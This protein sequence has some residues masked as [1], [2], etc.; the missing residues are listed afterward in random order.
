M[1]RLAIEL[2]VRLEFVPIERRR[3]DQSSGVAELL[4]QGYCDVIIG[5]IA[6]TTARAGLMQL[7]SPYLDETLGFVV[8]DGDRRRFESWDTIARR[9]PLTI[10]RAG[11][12]VLRRAGCARGCQARGSRPSRPSTPCSLRRPPTPTRSRSRRSADRRGRCATRSTPSSSRCPS[13]SRCRWRSR[14][15]VD[16]PE[17]A[18]FVNTWID[19]KRRD[20]TLDDALSVLD[21]RPRPRRLLVRA[22]RSSGTCC[23]GSTRFAFEPV[24]PHHAQLLDPEPQRVRDGARGAPPRCRRR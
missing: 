11:R 6:V 24:R 2:G 20:G 19:L 8:P 1:H 4:R 5:G 13:R 14:C 12:A 10:A 16:E 17:L 3:L 7:S 15:R 9:G 18:T 21:P 23:T 22:G